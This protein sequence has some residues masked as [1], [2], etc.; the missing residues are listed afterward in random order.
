M[1]T[2]RDPSGT[3]SW[4]CPLAAR[5]VPHH[6]LVVVVE[7]ELGNLRRRRVPDTLVTPDVLE[8]AIEGTDPVRIPNDPRV[9][10]QAHDHALVGTL[11]VQAIELILRDLEELLALPGPLE[12]DEERV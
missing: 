5:E 2:G 4:R 8:N 12:H 10:D 1:H 7:V 6:H 3:H 11:G 9:E